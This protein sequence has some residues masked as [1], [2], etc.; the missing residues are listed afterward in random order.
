MLITNF[1]IWFLLIWNLY[2]QSICKYWNCVI[3]YWMC[4]CMFGVIKIQCRSLGDNKLSPPFGW[5]TCKISVFMKQI[6][7]DNLDKS[8]FD[9]V[10]FYVCNFVNIWQKKITESF[11]NMI[12]RFQSGVQKLRYRFA[13][14]TRLCLYELYRYNNVQI[15]LNGA[16]LYS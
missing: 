8:L 11:Q 1:P 4:Y 6:G 5:A 13:L 9:M 10:V 15:F 2:Q 7:F 16:I 12:S 14:L 3:V